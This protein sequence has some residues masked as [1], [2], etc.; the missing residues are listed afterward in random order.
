MTIE[1]VP[2]PHTG[3]VDLRDVRYRDDGVLHL[4]SAEWIEFLK[5]LQWRELCLVTAGVWCGMPVS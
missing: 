5:D 2:C 1:A 4:T 3:C